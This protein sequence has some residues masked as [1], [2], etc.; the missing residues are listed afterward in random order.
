MDKCTVTCK[1][2]KDVFVELVEAD[3]V[4]FRGV[5]VLFMRRVF[6]GSPAFDKDEVVAGFQRDRLISFIVN[7]S[8]KTNG[9]D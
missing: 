1:N 9:G 8:G 3:T 6:G 5:M 7:G 4:D 2:G